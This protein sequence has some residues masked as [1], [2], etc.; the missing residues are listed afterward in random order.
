M[1]VLCILINADQVKCDL[2]LLFKELS[3]Y[4]DT[5]NS[6][7]LIT[8]MNNFRIGNQ[9]NKSMKMFKPKNFNLELS[10][11]LYSSFDIF[12]QDVIDFRILLC[13]IKCLLNPL[14]NM[15]DKFLGI[16]KQNV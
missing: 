16:F 8:S 7:N 15:V 3:K 13:C 5:N 4:V 14:Q 2:M 9:F 12:Y 6:F 10:N 1:D 11:K